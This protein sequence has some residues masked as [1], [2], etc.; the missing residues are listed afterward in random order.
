MPRNRIDK[1]EGLMTSLLLK[2]G[3]VYDSA[4]GI[5]G[6]RLD[7][8]VQ[9]KKIVEVAANIEPKDF[10]EVIDVTDKIVAPGLI[11]LH[12]HVF[13]GFN[14]SGVHPDVGESDQV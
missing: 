5:K 1:R 6:Q 8:S 14:S 10:D 7:V 12:C 2:N 13:H 3:T 4:Q 9:D 11:D